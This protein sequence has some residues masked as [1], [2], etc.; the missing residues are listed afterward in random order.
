MTKLP[1]D[2]DL[3]FDIKSVEELHRIL[4]EDSL[5]ILHDQG[6]LEDLMDTYAIPFPEGYTRINKSG[7]PR[8][9]W[10]DN[11]GGVFNI[12]PYSGRIRQI[13]KN[14]SFLIR[15]TT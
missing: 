13:S 3:Y 11:N 1:Y 9:V 4:L 8:I 6:E 15:S 12:R 14:E 5:D 7:F 2:F 10:I